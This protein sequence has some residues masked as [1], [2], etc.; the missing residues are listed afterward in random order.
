MIPVG[1]FQLE[2]CLREAVKNPVIANEIA[3]LDPEAQDM[4]NAV[5]VKRHSW[6]PEEQ[7]LVRTVLLQSIAGIDWSERR[8]GPRF[9]PRDAD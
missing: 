1:T 6:S 3:G 5:F 7:G 8:D 2:A 4:L 9:P